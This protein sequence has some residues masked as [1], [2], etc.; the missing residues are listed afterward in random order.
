MIDDESLN[1]RS[2]RDQFESY[3]TRVLLG[4]LASLG[5]LVILLNAPL[6]SAT[7]TTGWTVQRPSERIPIQ[8]IESDDPPSETAETPEEAPP[9]TRHTV[10]P[11]ESS[12]GVSGEGP[13][14]DP[15]SDEQANGDTGTDV[16]S[17]AALSA[18]DKYPNIVG[19]TGALYLNIDYP[20]EAIRE[21]I[22][23]QLK[24]TFTV[25]KDGGVR[26]IHV[27]KPLHPLCDSAAVE[28]LRSIKF[29]PAT[30]DGERVP[31]RMSLPIR[32]RLKSNLD[33]P[34]QSTRNSPGG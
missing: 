31:V 21:R 24:L 17:V 29:H 9:P 22:E 26:R 30:R 2:R 14:E 3:T 7:P 1:R 18:K 8:E 4:L 23:G 32:F 34:L 15:A 27:S 13:S 19:G 10:Q 20:P 25:T 11:I 12:Q 16:V 5:L 28:G 33:L 6:P